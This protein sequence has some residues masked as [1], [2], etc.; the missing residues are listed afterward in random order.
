[1]AQWLTDP[2]RNHE[3]AGLIPGLAQWARP[4]LSPT[5]GKLQKPGGGPKKKKKRKKKK[6]KKKKCIGELRLGLPRTQSGLGATCQ[7]HC[8][9]RSVPGTR[10]ELNK[11]DTRTLQ[12]KMTLDV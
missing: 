5:T 10:R 12:D 1:M 4:P 7:K 11:F 2:T 3:V 9:P 8:W 6:K